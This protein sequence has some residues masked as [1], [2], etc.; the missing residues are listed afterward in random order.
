MKA[1]AIETGYRGFDPDV[2]VIGTVDEVAAEL[3]S[4]ADVGVDEV[5]VRHL[6]EDQA[7]VLASMAR[8]ADV[9]EALLAA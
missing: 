6:A 4:L 9:R 3:R 2:L 7:E 5:A 1:R 8:L